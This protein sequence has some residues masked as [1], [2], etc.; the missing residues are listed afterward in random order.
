[1]VV[2]PAPL[3]QRQG[4]LAIGGRVIRCALGK[5]GISAFK[6]EGDGATPLGR[7]RVLSA[8]VRRDRMRPLASGLSLTPIRAA[9]GWCDAPGDRNY[10]WPVRLPYPASCERMRRDDHL[11]DVVIVLDANIRPRRR[12][13][14]SAIFFHLARPGYL[15]TE[16]CVAVSRRDMEWLLPRLSPRT[17]LTVVR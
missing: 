11:Y 3:D 6:R 5:G 12:G 7:M 2:R 16:G 9:D 13:M 1:M 4:L 8:Y 15:P 14:G 17:N 10:N